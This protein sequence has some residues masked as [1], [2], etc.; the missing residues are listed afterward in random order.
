MRNTVRSTWLT[1]GFQGTVEP[2]K[3]DPDARLSTLAHMADV[4]QQADQKQGLQQKSA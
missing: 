3:E 4:S 2:R 1:V